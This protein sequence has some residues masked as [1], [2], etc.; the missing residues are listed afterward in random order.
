MY[1]TKG[2]I[3][4]LL[5]EILQFL[6]RD[7]ELRHLRQDRIP[8]PAV[9]VGDEGLEAVDSVQRDLA[10]IL[11]SLESL[12]QGVLFAELKNNLYHTARK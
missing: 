6:S 4:Y 12:M 1:K 7:L 3:T 5:V 8:P 9:D 2:Q 10:L 11:Q